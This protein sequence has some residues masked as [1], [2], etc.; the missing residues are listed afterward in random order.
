MT[1]MTGGPPAALKRAFSLPYLVLYGLGTTLGAG[2]YVLIGEVVLEAGALAPLAFLVAATVAGFTAL[3]FAEFTSRYPE[4][5]GEAVYVSAGFKA[6]WLPVLV[7]LMVVCAGVVSSAALSRGVVGY[8]DVFIDLNDALVV[9]LAVGLLGGLAILGIQESI[10]VLTVMTLVEAGALLLLIGFGLFVDLE[11]SGAAHVAAQATAQSG[12]HSFALPPGSVAGVLG[13]AV[14][15]FYAFIGFEDMVNV[16]EE[17]KD[18]RR[19]LPLAIVWVLIVTTVIYVGVAVIATGAAGVVD[20]AAE[21][22]PLAA[23]FSALTGAPPGVLAAVGLIAVANGIL[24]QIIMASRVLYGLGNKG[25][26]ASWFAA[27]DPRTQTPIRATLVV[28]AIVLFL[29]LL[30]DVATLAQIT[31]VFILMVFTAVNASLVRVKRR[32]GKGDARFVV[33]LAVP[34]IGFVIALFFAVYSAV[35]LFIG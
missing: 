29:A 6:T 15:A 30:W 25:M 8:L 32:E 14:L 16:A 20:Y 10:A 12:A 13:A 22:A 31:S 7:G 27:V 33:P 26:V 11:A 5:A 34:V 1:D 28:M 24:I 21:S 17:V 18:A 4:S 2:I 9:V 3:S 23:L 19:T 35:D